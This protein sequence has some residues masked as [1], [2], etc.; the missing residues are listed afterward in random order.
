MFYRKQSIYRYLRTTSSDATLLFLL[1]IMKLF[2]HFEWNSS[3][4]NSSSIGMKDFV[5]VTVS[6]MDSKLK[7]KFCLQKNPLIQTPDNI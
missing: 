6:P 3:I 2:V 1:K 5:L 4:V 7:I